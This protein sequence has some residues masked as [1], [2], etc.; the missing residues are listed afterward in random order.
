[1]CCR[2]CPLFFFTLV[3]FQISGN[4]FFHVSNAQLLTITAPATELFDQ[5]NSIGR[6]LHPNLG[7]WHSQAT[8][9]GI[10]NSTNQISTLMNKSLTLY[11]GTWALFW[12]STIKY[13]LV[14]PYTD[15][16]SPSNKLVPPYTYPVPPN[17]IQYHS[18]LTLYHDVPTFFFLAK[19][20]IF[21]RLCVTL[22]MNHL[23]YTWSS[24]YRT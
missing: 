17:T 1:M 9:S 16:L 12:P 21:N 6:N 13:Q 22:F 10:G 19:S 11:E 4:L 18:V 14:L 3:L 24:F 7:T 2:F 15:P 20:K 5:V 8:I 23:Q